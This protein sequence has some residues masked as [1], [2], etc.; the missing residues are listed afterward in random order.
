[1]PS[2]NLFELIVAPTLVVLVIGYLLLIVIL[3]VT[4]RWVSPRIAV[5]C[6]AFVIAFLSLVA[7]KSVAGAAGFDWQ[8]KLHGIDVDLLSSQRRFKVT[9]FVAVLALVWARRKSMVNMGRALNSLGCALFVLAI[10]R[11]L[12]LWH[13]SWAYTELSDG[14]DTSLKQAALAASTRG[15]PRRVVWVIF[16]E[17][18]F[19]RLFGESIE[20]HSG[21]ANFE[22]MARESVFATNANSPASDTL[23][24]IPA[25]LAGVPL[26]GQGVRIDSA[27]SMSLEQLDGTLV[28]FNEGN[29]IFGTLRREGL[30]A[31]V[32][33]FYQPYC[34]LFTLQRCKTFAWPKVG[35]LDSA[36]WENVP[37]VFT[38]R[39]GAGNYWAGITRSSLD[40]LPQFLAREDALTFV[41][42][43]VPHLPASYA[44][45]ILNVHA[46][47]NPLT[48]YSRNLMLADRVLGEILSEVEKQSVHR[49]VLLIV[50]T[51]H[52]LRKLWFQSSG[53]EQSRRILFSVWKV[54]EKTGIVLS[55]PVSTVNTAAMIDD[56]LSGS[57]TTQSDIANW[58]KNQPVYPSYIALHR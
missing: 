48:E 44:D 1:L 25:L 30:T 23:Y 17:T 33:G 20:T 45:E 16:D 57:L 49:D 29:S 39:A 18:D 28:P 55:T 40:L 11:V 46:S 27:G 37:G 56:F 52:W 5:I 54:G 38:D 32:L 53:I 13:G 26:G 22:R 21:L 43:N 6:C 4:R 8:D 14:R 47:T 34:K 7:M 50:T 36:I 42:L 24:S 19:G 15:L 51:D 10:V 3:W 12:M 41:H 2:R 9:L 35:G 31:S 58:W